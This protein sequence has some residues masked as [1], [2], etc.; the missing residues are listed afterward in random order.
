MRSVPEG[1][2]KR[3]S[4]RGSAE[5]R[6]RRRLWALALMVGAVLLLVAFVSYTPEDQ[7][8]A[9]L[10]WGDI[11]GLLR[12]EPSARLKAETTHNWLGLLGAVLAQWGIVVGIGYAVLAFPALMG[13]W[14]WELLHRPAI[15][16]AVWRRSAA[17]GTFAL[18]AA[19]LAGA[20]RGIPSLAELPLEWSGMVGAFV[21]TVLRQF[22]GTVGAVV[23]L[24][25]A[26]VAV[27][28]VEFPHL[29]E[30]AVSRGRLLWARGRDW[31]ER[32]K[33]RPRKRTGEHATWGSAAEPADPAR[34]V[35]I[36]VPATPA[37]PSG[38]QPLEYKRQ[39][40]A[41]PMPPPP[42]RHGS[43]GREAVEEPSREVDTAPSCD[44]PPGYVPP[45]SALLLPGEDTLEIDEE[46][47]RRNAR[48]LQEKLETFRIGIE[49]VTVTPGPVV[50]QY[51]FVPAAGVKVSQ[52]ESLA[53]DI[54]LA[55]KAPGVRIIAPVP[56]R[57]TVAV[58]I[59]NHRRALVRFR[60]IVEAPSFAKSDFL[61]PLGLGKTITGEVYCT[62]L[63]RMPHL[64]IAG[65]TGSGK[66]VGLNTMILSLLFRLPPPELKLVIIDPKK[67]ELTPYAMLERHFLALSPEV[68]E[69]ITTSPEAAVVTLKAVELEMERRYD[70]L[71]Q[72]GQR[73]IIEYNRRVREGKLGGQYRP[74]P[75]I[76]VV[77]DE[78]ADLMLTAARAVEEPITRL[79]QLAR[80]VG[81]HLLVATQRPSVDVLTGLIKANFPARIAYQ[82][83]SRVDSRVILDMPGAEQLL[84]HGDMLF[85]P[86]GVPKPIR[87]Q[88]AYVSTEEV[89]AVCSFIAQQPGYEQPYW[90]PSVSEQGAGGREGGGGGRDPLFAEAARL[91]VR[92]QQGSVSLLQRRLK[93][94][95]SRAARL[96]DE[97]E[98]AGIVGPADGSRARQVLLRS[99]AD[100]EGIV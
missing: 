99:E 88:N 98:A 60:S 91:V 40:V 62:D 47:L 73:N 28:L 38:T 97:L 23:L 68:R 9:G 78:L 27:L 77:V 57:G 43:Q 81:I 71:A 12:A 29:G 17:I 58:E 25:A 7:Q 65:A 90:L 1:L 39:R 89:E 26:I 24:T 30:G 3:G 48:L 41:P 46:E 45:S 66:S 76:V 53:D 87:L 93:I 42:H 64:L 34:I 5:Q 85:L 16:P 11:V 70:V 84:G 75:Y 31:W 69:P 79:A 95:Y 67:V 52:I 51:E 80:A 54:A 4:R 37:E 33:R 35:R 61:L 20:L 74:L 86:G 19:S 18:L 72:A 6:H 50:T 96:M 59:P 83:A 56:G 22:A 15:G 44:E 100:L 49:N 21:G 2:P 32:Q 13:W 10:Q 14:A 92:H 36:A 63:A 55:L 82:V 8:N 94:G